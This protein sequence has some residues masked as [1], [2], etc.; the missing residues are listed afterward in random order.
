[1]TPK[2]II[3]ANEAIRELTGIALPYSVARQLAALKKRLGEEFRTVSE[4]E[5]TLRKKYQ[6]EITP[7]NR[8][9]FPSPENRQ[10]FSDEWDKLLEDDDETV[11][12]PKVD[13][14]AYVDELR[15]SAAAL[16]A[17]EDIV[18]FEKEAENG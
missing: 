6:G 1:M 4:M 14:S 3:Q 9:K 2:Q 17:L 11:Q 5:T 8:Y 15:I 7:N 16:A 10:A 13:L 18:Q 12:L